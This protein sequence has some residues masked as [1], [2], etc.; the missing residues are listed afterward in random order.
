MNILHTFGDSHAEC[1]AWNDV[2]CFEVKKHF[3]G[4]NT[5]AAFGL[6]KLKLLNIKNFDVKDNEAVCFCFGEID[7]RAHIPK[8][9]ISEQNRMMDYIVESYLEAINLNVKQYKELTVLV[10]NIVPTINITD[11]FLLE[12]PKHIGQSFVGS[13][14]RRKEVTA[15]MNKKLKENCIKNGYLFVDVFDKYCDKDG[16]MNPEYKDVTVH[17][18]NGVFINEFLKNNLKW[19]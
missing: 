17:I 6:Q 12:F 2:D 8:M 11:S 18:T 9:N 4:S 5:M 13:A 14:V 19:N 3:T 15:Y 16:F 10:L 1:K 7:C